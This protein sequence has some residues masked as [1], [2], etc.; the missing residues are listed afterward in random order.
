MEHEFYA[1]SNEKY[2]PSLFDN[3]SFH[4]IPEEAF[5]TEAVY[6]QD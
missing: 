6:L 2:E 3:E 4:G 5:E 1:Y